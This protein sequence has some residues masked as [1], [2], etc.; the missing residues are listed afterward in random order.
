MYA[1]TGVLL[2]DISQ[3]NNLPTVA[4]GIVGFSVTS[5]FGVFFVD[6]LGK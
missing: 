3:Q 4:L 2:I 5:Y 1:E 6:P